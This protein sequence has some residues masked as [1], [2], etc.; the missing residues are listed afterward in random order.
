MPNINRG[1]RESLI[2][3]IFSGIIAILLFTS[4]LSA[5]IPA[6]LQSLQLTI[7]VALVCVGALIGYSIWRFIKKW[8]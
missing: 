7:L 5:T 1:E 2:E 3:S 4:A 6:Q 8:I